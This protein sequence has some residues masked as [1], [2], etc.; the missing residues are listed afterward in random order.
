MANLLFLTFTAKRIRPLCHRP[1]YWE[2]RE[3]EHFFTRRARL[4]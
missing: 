3:A 2:D 1:R 4:E